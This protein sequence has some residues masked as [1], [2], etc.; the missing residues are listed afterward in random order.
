MPKYETLKEAGYTH[1]CMSGNGRH[2]LRNEDGKYELWAVCKNCASSAL[3]YKNTHLEF[4]S[5]NVHVSG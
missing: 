1:V 2:I 3:I 4:V 5:S